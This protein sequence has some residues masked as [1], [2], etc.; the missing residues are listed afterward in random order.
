MTE[1]SPLRTCDDIDEVVLNYAE[2]KGLAMKNPYMKEKMQVETEIN[3]INLLKGNWLDNKESYKNKIESL[4][5]RIKN[6]EKYINNINLD[7][8]TYKNNKP[9]DFEI[10]LNNIKFNAKNI[11]YGEDLMMNLEIFNNINSA[12][13]INDIFYK[14][15]TNS[16]SVTQSRDRNKWLKNL[17]DAVDVYMFLFYYIKIWHM[18]T[19]DNIMKVEKRVKKEISVVIEL[20]K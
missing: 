17:Q 10:T 18:D 5:I 12:L 11:K 15:N 14:Y 1:K 4:P 2:I 20:L 6:L 9:I 3:K 16:N 13:F 8:K 7:I 19:I